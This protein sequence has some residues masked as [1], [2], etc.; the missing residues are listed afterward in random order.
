MDHIFLQTGQS[1][2]KSL[3]QRSRNLQAGV[4]QPFDASQSSSGKFHFLTTMIAIQTSIEQNSLILI[5]EPETSLHPNWQMGYIHNLKKIF[6]TWHG[7]HFLIV[8]HSHFFVSDLPGESSE[9]IALNGNAPKI[10]AEALKFDT[11]GWSP[12]EILYKI[13]EVRTVRNHFFELDLRKLAFLINSSSD[14]LQ[15][16]R[17]IIGK[18]S[19]F[20]FSPDDAL[21][22]LIAEA[23]KYLGGRV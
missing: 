21:T 6:K 14:D 1:D 2:A 11:F 23:E 19:R 16:I 18:I 10:H 8:S 15:E 4:N 12:D 5:D 9:I 20:P 17:R 13:F 22:A 3:D 7:S